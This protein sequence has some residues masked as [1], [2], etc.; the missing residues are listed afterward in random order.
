MLPQPYWCR[1]TYNLSI[2]FAIKW[3]CGEVNRKIKNA[4]VKA[5]DA[6]PKEWLHI[7]EGGLFAH[8]VSQHSSTKYSPFFL[9]YNRDPVLLIDVKFSF[10]EREVN[11]TKVFDEKTFEAILISA[12]RIRGEIHES[13]TSKT[14]K[15]QGKQT[16][17]DFDRRHLSNSK[18]KVG[19]LILLR[20][21]KRKDRKEESFHLH[22]LVHISFPKLHLKELNA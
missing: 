4:L 19:D 14:R 10:T 5:L 18:I 7:I 13:A 2:S 11:E 12:I 9:I 3:S 20:N 15:A 8:R 6:H 22:G 17:K 21:N 1:A 16:K